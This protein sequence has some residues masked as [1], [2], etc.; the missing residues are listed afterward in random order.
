[1]DKQTDER[2]NERTDVEINKQT[3]KQLNGL[4]KGIETF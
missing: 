2:I 1:M 3:D 4:Y